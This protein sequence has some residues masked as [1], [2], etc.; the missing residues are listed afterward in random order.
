MG[1]WAQNQASAMAI[2]SSDLNPVENEWGEP[3]TEQKKHQHEAGN[4]KV[5]VIL[6]EGIVSCQVFSSSIIGE[7]LEL[8]NWQ[9]VSKIR[10]QN[11]INKRCR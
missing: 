3:K 6:D 8:L 9:M 4:L 11:L 2:Q 1:H 5:W 7:H 10:F